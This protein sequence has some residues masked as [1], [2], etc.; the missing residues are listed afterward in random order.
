MKPK[1]KQQA[2]NQAEELLRRRLPG[3]KRGAVKDYVD[4]A[5]V[6][7]GE[8][9]DQSTVGV[10]SMQLKH[11]RKYL[12]TSSLTSGTLYKKWKVLEVVIKALGKEEWLGILERGPWVRP[13]GKKGPLK[14]GCPGM[15]PL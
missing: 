7:A 11:V 14:G 1:N 4:R 10:Y 15:T 12:T 6:V 3:S 2:I 5:G 13:N 8:I 9:Y